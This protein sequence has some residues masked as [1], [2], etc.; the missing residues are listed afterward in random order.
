MTDLRTIRAYVD[1]RGQISPEA[2][3][4]TMNFVAWH[5]RLKM[6]PALELWKAL[7]IGIAC[8]QRP[9]DSLQYSAV[10]RFLGREVTEVPERIEDCRG[11]A[12]QLLEHL[13]GTA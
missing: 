11:L 7:A 2:F 6:T 9:I 3:T 10:K 1:I 4:Q 8:E 13:S 12:E 5:N